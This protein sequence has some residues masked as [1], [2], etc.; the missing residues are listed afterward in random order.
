VIHRG[1]ESPLKI[2]LVAARS[3]LAVRNEKQLEAISRRAF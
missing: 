3:Q 1:F 2:V